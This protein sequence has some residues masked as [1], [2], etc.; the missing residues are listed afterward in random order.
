MSNNFSAPRKLHW[1]LLSAGV[2]LVSGCSRSS[3]ST[4][5][6]GPTLPAGA[7][8]ILKSPHL[9]VG[10]SSDLVVN[11]VTYTKTHQPDAPGPIELPITNPGPQPAG[12]CRGNSQYQFGS[13]LYDI[14]GPLGGNPT[15]HADFYGNVFPPQVPEGIHTRLYARAYAIASPCNGKRVLFISQ[16]IM[17]VSVLERQTILA[18]IAADPVLSQYYDSNNLMISGTHTHSAGGGFG[19]ALGLPDLSATLPSLIN[20]PALWVTSAVIGNNNFDAD[21]FKVIVDGVVQAIRR[22]HANLET[23]PEG[24]SIKLSIGQLLNANINRT[25]PGYQQNSSSERAAYINQD[26]RETNVDKRFL[27]LNLVRNNGSVVG[28]INWFGV[29]PTSM[30]NHNL[31]TSSDSKGYASLGFEKLMGTVYAPDGAGPLSG[32]DN[33]VAAFA[34]TD[35]GDSI[36]DLFVFD[37]DVNGGNG[38]G[39][40]VPIQFRGG[41]DDPYNFNQPGYKRGMPKATAISGTK[42]LAQALTQMAQGSALSGPVDYRYFNA[43]FSA[44]K[45]TDP[46]VLASLSYADLPANLY[47]PT[48]TTCT[49]AAGISQLN[50]GVNGLDFGAAGYACAASAPSPYLSQVRNGYN[51]LYNGV[52]HILAEKYDSHIEV[53]FNAVVA[54]DALTPAL[55][56]LTATLPQYGCQAEKPI[57]PISLPGA[58]PSASPIPIQIFRIGN[59]AILGIPFEVTTMS[60]RR[61]RKT[62]LDAL[63]PVG[64]DTVVISGLSNDYQGYM[65]TRE[66]YTAQMYEGASTTFGPWQLAATQQE[67]RKLALTM[68]NNQAAPNGIAPPSASTGPASPITVD[69][70]ANFGNVVNDVLSNHTQGDTVD[71]S[72]VAGYPG[73]DLKTMSSYLYVERKN[74]QGAWNVVATDGRPELTFIWNSNPSFLNSEMNMAGSSTAQAL[75]KIP[76]NTPAGTYR[77]RH[78]GVSRLSASQA[79]TPYEGISS[80]FK[81]S[82]TPAEC[83]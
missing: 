55:C 26:G 28:V 35:E 81:I 43:D 9:E 41:T 64:V 34:Q 40:G 14:T 50:G 72:F 60:A 61:L 79:P 32:T 54:F 22:A 39:Q 12:A 33:F 23:H 82:G 21:N 69:A 65:A 6:T 8:C 7:Q 5:A 74:A 31:L 24:A 63:S 19:I 17:G 27:Q 59:L 10:A 13:G 53:P 58:I 1:I 11:G 62:V 18:R 45:V 66:E 42:Q 48:K 83:P 38:P 70:P 20:T 78:A 75:W 29:H 30:G 46:V 3:S 4:A 76:M 71:V 77:I 49:S 68:A 16:D 80:T 47:T 57:S 15:G 67:S 25:P 36:S 73:N 44:D 52:G 51:G 2:V 37:K 56:L